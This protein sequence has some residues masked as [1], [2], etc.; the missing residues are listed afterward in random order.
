MTQ[1]IAQQINMITQTYT[2]RNLPKWIRENQNGKRDS[3]VNGVKLDVAAEFEDT[4]FPPA[5]TKSEM[6]VTGYDLHITF[7]VDPIDAR[8]LEIALHNLHQGKLLS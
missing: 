5:I 8:F 1:T 3:F 6:D 2:F 4:L 7:A